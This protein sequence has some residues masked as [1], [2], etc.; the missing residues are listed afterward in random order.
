M[1][2]GE[3][4]EANYRF[5]KSKISNQIAREQ[6]SIDR[7]TIDIKEIYLKVAD[8]ELLIEKSKQRQEDMQKQIN[9]IEEELKKH[10]GG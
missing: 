1:D 3:W 5:E 4:N 7:A 10:Y 9:W 6:I 2:K 8:L